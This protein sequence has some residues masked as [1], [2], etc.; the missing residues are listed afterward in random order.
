VDRAVG[1]AGLRGFYRFM[2]LKNSSQLPVMN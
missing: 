2:G 1:T